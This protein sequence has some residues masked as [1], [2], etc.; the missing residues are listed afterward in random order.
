MVE[1]SGVARTLAGMGCQYVHLTGG[2]PTVRGDLG[3]IVR[4]VREHG[5]RVGISTNGSRTY[6]Y[7][8]GLIDLGVE[9]FSI[10][11]D[12]HTEDLN[13]VFTRVGGVFERVV[14]NIRQLAPRVYVNVGVVFNDDNIQYHN[15]ICRFIS[16]LGVADIRIMTSTKYNKVMKLG[17]DS[18][19]LVKHPILKYRVDNFNAGRNMRGSGLST[20]CKCYLVRDDVTIYGQDFYSCA[21]Y[22][23][24]GGHPIGKFGDG[25]VELREEWF[26]RHNSHEDPI[27]RNYCM[28]FKCMF[29]DRVEQ[30]L[31]RRVGG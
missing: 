31:A 6:D 21:V 10:S 7:Y 28:D 4:V 2:E 17:V 18:D 5:M 16:G 13:R 19:L 9:L 1:V 20:T 30:Y 27:C 24:E 23:R 3:D 22:L 12:V 15:E 25:N 8:S 26:R 14:S 11:L 29:N